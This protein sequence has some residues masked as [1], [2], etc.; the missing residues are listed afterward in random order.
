MNNVNLKG[1]F[2][3]TEILQKDEMKNIKGGGGDKCAV[4]SMGPGGAGGTC[5]EYVFSFAEASAMA[6]EFNQDVDD[7]YVY[8][9]HCP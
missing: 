2:S 3:S 6:N 9:F 4:C 5:G 7:G 8:F 1:F